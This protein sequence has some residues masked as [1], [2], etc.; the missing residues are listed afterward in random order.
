MLLR[1]HSG[2]IQGTILKFYCV[3]P[4]LIFLVYERVSCIIAEFL[5]SERR[6]KEAVQASSNL[7]HALVDH[8][9]VG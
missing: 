2:H 9:N 4:K 1:D 7:T 3:S 5:S 6:R 8:L